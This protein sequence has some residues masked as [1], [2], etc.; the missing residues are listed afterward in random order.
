MKFL[1]VNRISPNGMPRFT[2]SHLG[3]LCLP[4]FLELSH[5]MRKPTICIGEN[6]DADQLTTKL[7]SSFVFAIR[8]VQTLFFLNLKFQASNCLLWLYSSVGIGPVMLKNHIVGYLVR[9]LNRTS[10]YV[11]LNLKFQASSCL[12]GLYSSVGIGPVQKPHC[13]NNE[14]QC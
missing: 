6:K 7:I 1:Y 2:A 14:N 5:L 8:K 4:L 11:F 9:W 13:W 3:L 12:L 10:V